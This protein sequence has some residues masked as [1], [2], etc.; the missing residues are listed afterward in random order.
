MKKIL[1]ILY[2]TL[3]IIL[4]P[5]CTNTGPGK[6]T[7]SVDKNDKNIV[8]PPPTKLSL[9]K[10]KVFIIVPPF[11]LKGGT[12][13]GGSYSGPGVQNGKFYPAKAGTGTHT[14][15]YTANNKKATDTI[16]VIGPKKRVIDPNCSLCLGTGKI[17]CEPKITCSD[18][19]GFGKIK[20]GPCYKCDKT[21]KVRAWYKMWIGK[22]NCENCNGLG[23]LYTM[24][25]EC[26]ELGKVKC[27]YCKGTGKRKCQN[28]E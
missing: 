22:K 24:C 10:E 11:K 9:N 13:E 20:E 2:V 16:Q 21:G 7:N 17:F 1:T 28:C 14:I 19:E 27:P 4:C 15:T 23:S 5:S 18:C 8:E 25:S 6:E 26:K 12:P 3:I